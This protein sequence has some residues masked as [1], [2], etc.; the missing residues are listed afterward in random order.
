M[1]LWNSDSWG[2]WAAIKHKLFPV[3][4]GALL[5]APVTASA[6]LSLNCSATQAGNAVINEIQTQNSFIEIYFMRPADLGSWAIYVAGSGTTPEKID[7]GHGNCFVNGTAVADNASSGATA[8]TWPAGTF[9]A[10]HTAVTIPSK[11]EVLLVDKQSTLTAGN[12][13]VIDYINYGNPTTDTWTVPS[14][15]GTTYDAHSAANKDIARVPDGS[16]TLTDNGDNST[17]GTNNAP[18]PSLL[19]DF[20]FDECSWSS[21]VANSVLD[22]SG[23]NYHATP[24]G[25]STFSGGK[26]YRAADL[27]PN[28]ITDYLSFNTAILNGRTNFSVALWFKTAVTKTQQELLQALGTSSPSYDDVEIYLRNSSEVVVNV[29]DSADLVYSVGKTLTDNSWHHLAFTRY[30]NI[31]CLYI[32]GLLDECKS[33]YATTALTLRSGAFLSGQEQDAYG[34]SFTTAQ[35]FVGYLDELKFFNGTLGASHVVSIYNNESA[36]KNYDGTARVASGCGIDH[37]RILHDGA[38]Q[39]CA[40]ETVTLQACADSACTT[41]YGGSMTVDLTSPAS[42]W[43]VDPVTFTGGTASVLLSRTT[44]G[45]LTLG[46]TATAPTASGATRC[47]IGATQDCVINFSSSAACF[48]AV[49]PGRSVSTPIYTKLA[50]GLFVLDVL[51]LSSSVTNPYAGTVSVA[52]VDPA[53]ASGN[54]ADANAGLL[55]EQVYTYTAADNGRKAFNFIYPN[56]AKNVRVRVRDTSINVPNCSADNFAIRPATLSLATTTPLDPA[57]NRL[58]A[59]E[60][61]NLTATPLDAAATA[62]VINTGYT[63]QPVVDATRVVDHSTP[64]PQPVGAALTWNNPTLPAPGAAA[65]GGFPQSTGGAVSNLFQYQDV[66]TITFTVDAVKDTGFTAVDQVTGVVAGVD[67]GLTGDCVAASTS[68]TL[69]GG[70]YGCYVGSAGLGPLGRFYPHHFSVDAN[71]SPACAAGGYTYMDDD[72]LGVTLEVKAQSKANAVATR[73][74]TPASTYVPVAALGVTLLNGGSPTDLLARLSQ[75]VVPARNWTA[76]VYSGSATYRFD[77]RNLAVPV[78]D[79]AYDSLRFHV[80]VTDPVDDVKITQ[81]NGIV[82]PPVSV[83][84][85]AATRVRFG[86]LWLGNAYGSE[87]RSLALPYEAQYWNG[88]AFVKNTLD[89]CTALTAANIGIGNYKGNINGT[90]LPATAISLGSFSGGAGSVVLAAPNVAGSA[91]VVVRLSGALDMCPAWLPAYPAGTPLSL[92][93]LRGKWC[94]SAYDQDPVARATFGIFGSSSKKGP[95]YLRENY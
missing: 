28:G 71:F 90:N 49:E 93:W 42:G 65:A 12:A 3:A 89:S 5:L 92:G 88:N 27:T 9:V 73:Y 64:A 57:A 52:L 69:S 35:N 61:F 4:L 77:A 16:G 76:G 30:G 63:G 94:G 1:R 31:G 66:G 38:G 48:D 62:A 47:Y 80:T 26:L 15:C 6:A 83:V 84:D 10:C 75:P 19:A 82:S 25:A 8:T 51:A 87:K 23:N 14:S 20:H 2:G 85:S 11:G 37:I 91:D 79:G 29:R 78:V 43:S 39:T 81:L 55:A 17:E 33:T 95:I 58:P 60:D 44:A 34:G 21:G 67:H 41:L 22:S 50:N 13:T 70:L 45:S 68:N 36:G 54:C 32:D 86:R 7:L 40:P 72:A 59:G 46:A 53:A 74:V 18:I 56:A 24:Y